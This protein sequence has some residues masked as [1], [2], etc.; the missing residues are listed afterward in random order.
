MKRTIPS[1]HDLLR[2]GKLQWMTYGEV[3][4]RYPYY[5]K[6]TIQYD[7]NDDFVHGDELKWKKERFLALAHMHTKTLTGRPFGR[8][9]PCACANWNK[10]AAEYEIGM[11][12]GY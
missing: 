10:I 9:V 6:W 4:E 5:V 7:R 1:E 12:L 11:I 3:M 8:S 2:Y